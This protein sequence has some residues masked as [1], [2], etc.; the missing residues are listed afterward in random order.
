M[1]KNIYS[2]HIIS[3]L[4]FGLLS[5]FIGRLLLDADAVLVLEAGV[6]GQAVVRAVAVTALAR[7]V[8]VETPESALRVNAELVLGARSTDGALINVH[9]AM[10]RVHL[11]SLSTFGTGLRS[12]ALARVCARLVARR[13]YFRVCIL[14]GVVVAYGTLFAG[15]TSVLLITGTLPVPFTGASAFAFP[16]ACADLA[17]GAFHRAGR[18]LGPV[19]I[20]RTTNLDGLHTEEVPEGGAVLHLPPGLQ[21][22]LPVVVKLV[23]LALPPLNLLAQILPDFCQPN[24]AFGVTRLRFFLPGSVAAFKLAPTRS[25]H[26]L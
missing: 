2:Y 7:L 11:V 4:F 8:T 16:V 22:V 23:A 20:R 6:A 18:T 12:R 25:F 10:F 13:A 19:V 24:L 3:Q 21:V 17:V 15:R 1:I 9:A 26:A 5:F 14:V